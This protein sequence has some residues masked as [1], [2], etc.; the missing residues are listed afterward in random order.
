VGRLHARPNVLH[1][2]R[3]E[4]AIGYYSGNPSHMTLVQP[5]PFQAIVNPKHVVKES[6]YTN[7]AGPGPDVWN[8]IK[9]IMVVPKP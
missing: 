8:G 3:I 1:L 2:G 5:H 6:N 7:N 9:V 4:V